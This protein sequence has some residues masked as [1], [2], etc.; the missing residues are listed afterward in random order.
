MGA[1]P[2]RRLDTGRQYAPVLSLATGAL[3][4]SANPSDQASQSGGIVPHARRAMRP[5][6]CWPAGSGGTRHAITVGLGT[7]APAPWGKS[8][9]RRHRRKVGGLAGYPDMVVR[10]GVRRFPREAG[11]TPGSLE[12]LRVPTRLQAR[13]T[14]VATTSRPAHADAVDTLVGTRGHTAPFSSLLVPRG[15]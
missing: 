11:D 15:A 8:A 9:S 10:S 6:A 2:S 7:P 5:S 12:G 14:N 13:G 1:W 4:A 3:P